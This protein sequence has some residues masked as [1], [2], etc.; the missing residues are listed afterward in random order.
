MK[1]T[2]VIT[3]ILAAAFCCDASEVYWGMIAG[4]QSEDLMLTSGAVGNGIVI[5]GSIDEYPGPYSS[6]GLELAYV[7]KSSKL[8]GVQV[9]LPYNIALTAM[10]HW[11]LATADD[12]VTES[13]ISNGRLVFDGTDDL[14]DNRYG[15]EIGIKN[16]DS[17]YLAFVAPMMVD[18]SERIYDSQVY[19][20]LKLEASNNRLSV[21]NSAFSESYIY[22][23]GELIPEPSSGVL[24]LLGI[25]GLALRRRRGKQPHFTRTANLSLHSN[26]Q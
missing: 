5:E 24:L 21:V 19:G 14:A 9:A 25:A 11:V 20:W 2:V 4:R 6:F 23:G 15:E 10:S 8:V 26:A 16:G 7:T 1:H 22:V 3:V 13:Y 17:L 12:L 18:Q